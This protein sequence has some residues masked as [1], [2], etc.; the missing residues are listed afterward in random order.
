[1]KVH[2]FILDKEHVLLNVTLISLASISG[3]VDILPGHSDMI[4][5]LSKGKIILRSNHQ[6]HMW[7]IQG[8]FFMIQENEV[9]IVAY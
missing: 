4:G 5:Q 2:V 1:M 7:Q 3:H 8:G 6:E 9:E